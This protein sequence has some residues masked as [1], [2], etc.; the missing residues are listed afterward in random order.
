M[1]IYFTL[2]KYI[3][4]LQGFGKVARWSLVPLKCL[5]VS[6]LAWFF[7]E[8]TR[9]FGWLG[10]MLVL[11]PLAAQG[12]G[13][14][15]VSQ[16]ALA[17]ARGEAFAATADNPS[18]VHY[19]PAGLTQLSGHE[20]RLGSY[21]L[22]FE[23][24][25]R[26]L[27]GAAN[28]GRTY[29]IDEN[30]AVA[31]QLFYSYRGEDGNLAFG[32]GIYAPHGAAVAWPQDTGFRAVATEGELTY[33]RVNPVLAWEP[34]E[35]LSLAAG[36]MVDHGEIVLEQGLLRTEQPFANV[37][38]FTGRDLAASCNLGLMWQPHETISLGATY[39][40]GT[41]MRFTGYTEIERQPII[42]PTVLPAEA[43]Y[44][45]PATAVAGISWRP[46]PAWNIEFNADWTGWSSFD[47]V[48]IRQ[49]GRAP[50]PVQQDIPVTLKWRDSWIYK[51]GV[52]RQL[53]DGWRVSAGYVFSENSVPDDYYSP[54]VADLDRH[55]LS[56]GVGR[57][58]ECWDFDLSYQFGFADEHR[59]RG[60]TP[61]SSPGRF[62]GQN[63]DGS[64][65]FT[66]HA[67]V[68]SLGLR[69]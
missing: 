5:V 36:L 63:G 50:F 47:E 6:G 34:V 48:T 49:A 51:F 8:V 17:A 55:F 31:P 29:G 54:L 20:L 22:D 4:L 21:A 15:L 1:P 59:V 60:S 45:F 23:P 3:W 52:T 56:I 26:P 30:F 37:F 38:R 35:G 65:D 27:P 40:A 58:C 68:M 16:D 10:P 57:D 43:V 11:L 61:S 28:A 24:S 9:G 32:L 18:A 64:Y 53:A 13:M 42:Q 19:N 25:F 39:R 46:S 62:V 66:S 33:L 12:N 69:F 44:D 67:L 7:G 14:R 41:R 2:P